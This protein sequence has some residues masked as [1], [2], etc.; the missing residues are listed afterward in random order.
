MQSHLALAVPSDSID[1]IPFSPN[2]NFSATTTILEMSF[3]TVTLKQG[4]SSISLI[5]T[6]H[7]MM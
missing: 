7:E 3:L 4:H 5:L 1:I 2:F 6:R